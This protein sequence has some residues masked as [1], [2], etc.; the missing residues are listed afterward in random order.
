MRKIQDKVDFP[1]NGLDLSD[2]CTIDDDSDDGSGGDLIDRYTSNIIYIH[3]HTYI[4][5]YT[6]TYIHIY[7]HTYINT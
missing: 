7:I 2:Y 5:K 6:Y 3:I 1:C 4:H